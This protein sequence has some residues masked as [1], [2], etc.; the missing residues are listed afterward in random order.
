MRD[1]LKR[2]LQLAKPYRWRFGLGLLCGFLAGALAPTLGLSLKLAVDVVF[3][4]Q[5]AGTNMAAVANTNS[6]AA[7]SLTAATN[8]LGTA[9]VGTNGSADEANG[10]APAKKG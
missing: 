10:S 9:V 1:Y 4:Q 2:V 5:K 3:P 8:S 7:V 6:I